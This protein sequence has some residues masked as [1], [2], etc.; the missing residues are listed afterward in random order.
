MELLWFMI[1]VVVAWVVDNTVALL[2]NLGQLFL[3]SKWI[4]I[5]LGLGLAA[6][7]LHPD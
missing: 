7:L 2:P 4:L 3:P 1:C 6:W 5:A